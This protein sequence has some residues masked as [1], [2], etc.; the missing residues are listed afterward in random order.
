[1][2]KFLICVFILAVFSGV[3]FWFGWT[4]IKV[5]PGEV[6][7]IT[8]KTDGV[9]DAYVQ[10]GEF[11]WYWQFLL[12]TNAQIQTFTIDP[13]NTTKTITG[14]LPSADF[15]SGYN[16]N[17]S[18]TYTISLTVEPQS[19][20][21][22]I[23]LNRITDDKTL[24][25]YLT[26]AADAVAQLTTNYLLNKLKDNQNYKIESIRRDDILRAININSDYPE[27]ELTVF[28]ITD[29]KVPD[30]K[31]YEKL[32]NQAITA[33]SIYKTDIPSVEENQEEVVNE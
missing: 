27:I 15:Y 23:K 1:M 3:I 10:N 2:K 5:K 6:G 28:A 24:D 12:P 31:L 26:N 17:Y 22:L 18:F 16:F 9:I 14:Q 25:A 8:T 29:S 19:V 4:E 21:N 11:S 20:I 7:I 13:V 30:F 32:Q 33:Q